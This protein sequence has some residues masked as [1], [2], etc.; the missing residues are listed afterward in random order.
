MSAVTALRVP[1]ARM[2]AGED[3]GEGAEGEVAALAEA[4]RGLLGPCAWAA[5]AFAAERGGG[6]GAAAAAAAEGIVGGSGHARRSLADKRCE[7]ARAVGWR[8]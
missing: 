1:D 4:A 3:G 2:G 5:A 7:M 8:G 6:F